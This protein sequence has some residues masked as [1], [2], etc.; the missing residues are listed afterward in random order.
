M[1][2]LVVN[3]TPK[4]PPAPSGTAA[5]ASV[6]AARPAESGVRTEFVR[7]VDPP[8]ARGAGD[9]AGRPSKASSR[10]EVPR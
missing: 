2:A 9:G 6:V 7:A 4:K 10:C 5:P 3:R 1:K 8:I